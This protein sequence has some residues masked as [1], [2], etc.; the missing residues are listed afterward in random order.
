MYLFVF[1]WSAALK[2]AR[3]ASHNTASPT[4]G[5][6]FA[7]FMSAMMLGSLIFS[8]TSRSLTLSSAVH[9]LS[10][11]IVLSAA[12]LLAIVLFKSE[13]LTLW[14]FCLFETCVGIYYPS[15]G[16]LKGQLVSDGIRGKV[17]GALRLPLN[18]FVVVTLGLTQE[19]KSFSANS[20]VM[21]VA[22]I[23]TGDAHRDKILAT[24]SGLLILAYVICQKY[25]SQL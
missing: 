19:G 6:V 9:T 3:E 16:Y 24:C 7:T 23:V 13:A 17:Y 18:L 22:N 10:L 20:S 11:A 12:S 1:F 8:L 14:A 4:F 2:S 25:L 5:L 15:M 21:M